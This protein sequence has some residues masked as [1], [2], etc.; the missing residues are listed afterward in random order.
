[1]VLLSMISL[2]G[3]LLVLNASAPTFLTTTFS[4]GFNDVPPST[5]AEC[6]AIGGLAIPI[7]FDCSLGSVETK[8]NAGEGY[9]CCLSDTCQGEWKRVWNSETKIYEKICDGK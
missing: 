1:M 9:I 2:L 7:A 5:L 8:G 6:Q 4:S 3:W